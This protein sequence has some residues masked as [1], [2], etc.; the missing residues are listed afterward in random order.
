MKIMKKASSCFHEI[1]QSSN[2]M[3]FLKFL[4]FIL[5]GI[6]VFGYIPALADGANNA[7]CLN[8]SVP[9]AL[10]LGQN[11]TASV[12]L[13]NTGTNTWTTD[14]APHRLGSQNPDDTL[15]W[16]PNR[17]ELPYSVNPGNSVTFYF[18]ATAPSGAGSYIFAWRMV[19]EGSGFFGET[20]TRSIA[21]GIQGISGLPTVTTNPPTFVTSYMASTVLNGIVNPNGGDTRVWFEWGETAGLGKTTAVQLMGNGTNLIP[22]ASG[23]PGLLPNHT[24]YYRA[25][26]QNGSGMI[27]GSMVSFSTGGATPVSP[28]VP[29]PIPIVLTPATSTVPSVDA[30]ILVPSTDNTAPAAGGEVIFTVLYKNVSSQLLNNVS[31]DVTLPQGVGVKSTNVPLDGRNRDTL[32][33]V[34]G[35]LGPQSQ[36]ALTIKFAL[37]QD[38]AENSALVFDTSLA[39]KDQAGQSRSVHAFYAFNVSKAQSSGGLASIIASGAG[40]LIFFLLVLLGMVIFYIVHRRRT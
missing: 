37:N 9:D 10:A 25:V 20:C 1:S 12:T 5:V 30:V 16:G 38:S 8:V 2:Y 14:A 36:G 15:R 26:A 3:K 28:S 4:P 11:F 32:H 40:L 34:L 24:Y 39:Y 27:P 21:V 13:R 7:S 35:T 19:E 18:N 23:L 33:F 6:F 29:R 22:F 17:V 31:I